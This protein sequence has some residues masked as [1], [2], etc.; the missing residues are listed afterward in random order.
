MDNPATMAT[1]TAQRHDKLSLQQAS[2]NKPEVLHQ[3]LSDPEED[4]EMP[5]RKDFTP[6]VKDQAVRF[7]LEE[8]E[9]RRVAV[10]CVWAARSE[11]VGDGGDALQLGEAVLSG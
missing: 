5:V 6:A 2:A 7:V 1:S 4:S 10:A 9:V 8:I 3:V 11:A